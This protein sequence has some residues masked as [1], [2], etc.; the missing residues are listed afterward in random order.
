MDAKK[1]KVKMKTGVGYISLSVYLLFTKRYI[2]VH[3]IVSFSFT[4]Y[5]N[6]MHSRRKLAT[7]HG[8]PLVRAFLASFYA[9]LAVLK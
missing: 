5:I 4:F 6:F 3:L 8:V 9:Q 1:E 7:I 2:S